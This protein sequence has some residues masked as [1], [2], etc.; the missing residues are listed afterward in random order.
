MRNPRFV[1]ERSR[2]YFRYAAI[3][4]CCIGILTL[5]AMRPS[6]VRP[7]KSMKPMHVAQSNKPARGDRVVTDNTRA[8]VEFKELYR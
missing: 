8:D 5:A 7:V 6:D 4:G 1:E 3:I 2:R